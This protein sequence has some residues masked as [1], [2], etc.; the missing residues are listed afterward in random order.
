MWRAAIGCTNF[1]TSPLLFSLRALAGFQT[2]AFDAGFL[3]IIIIIV[4]IVITRKPAFESPQ[5][6]AKK[7]T[8]VKSEVFMYRNKNE[9]MT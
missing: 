6:P 1:H 4:I 7:I 2:R 9:T 8:V 5:E 3:V